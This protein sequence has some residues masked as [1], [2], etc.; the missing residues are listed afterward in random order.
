MDV[1]GFLSKV[2]ARLTYS[3]AFCRVL[4]GVPWDR[5]GR[6]GRGLC[7]DSVFLRHRRLPDIHEAVP[8]GGDRVPHHT[9]HHAH[10]G[11]CPVVM[12]VHSCRTLAGGAHHV[13]RWPCIRMCIYRFKN[14]GLMF[15]RSFRVRR[16]LNSHLDERRRGFSLVSP[17]VKRG[18][19][20]RRTLSNFYPRPPP[21]YF[22]ADCFTYGSRTTSL[23]LCELHRTTNIRQRKK[24]KGKERLFSEETTLVRHGLV[25]ASRWSERRLKQR[26]GTSR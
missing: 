18:F 16:G 26:A 25:N 5:A 13:A 15:F 11:T 3:C 6:R 12:F 14:V 9:G 17:N 23:F 4:P 24:E 10:P 8:A 20:P 7:G 1:P 2:V 19:C 21:P 22:G